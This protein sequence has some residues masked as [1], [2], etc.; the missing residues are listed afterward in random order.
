MTRIAMIKIRI[1]LKITITITVMTIKIIITGKILA[2]LLEIYE[3]QT[4]V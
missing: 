4:G 3:P 2:F 1:R